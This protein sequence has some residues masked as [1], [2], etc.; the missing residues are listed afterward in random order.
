MNKVKITVLKRTFHEG[1]AEEYAV[2]G[3]GKCPAFR[4]GD[5]F[6]T[7]IGKPKNFCDED[8]KAIYQY[9]FAL[10]HGGDKVYN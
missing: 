5:V 1:L 4:E 3:F 2:E 6:Y 7:F 9:V 8:W 10:A